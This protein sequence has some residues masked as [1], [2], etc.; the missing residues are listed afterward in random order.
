MQR[1]TFRSLCWF[2]G[3]RECM[4]GRDTCMVVGI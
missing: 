4:F 3:V 1:A 2:L